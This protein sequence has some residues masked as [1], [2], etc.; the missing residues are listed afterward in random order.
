MENK[1]III[2][3]GSEGI[4]FGMATHL[5]RK[6]ARIIVASRDAGAAAEFLLSERSAFV[7]GSTMFIDGGMCL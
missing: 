1:V 6:G 2:S 7:T 5:A 4:G 3:G